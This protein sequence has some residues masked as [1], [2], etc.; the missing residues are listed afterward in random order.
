[1]LEE[2]WDGGKA[3]WKIWVSARRRPGLLARQA[4]LPDRPYRLQGQLAGAVAAGAGRRGAPASRSRRRHRAGAVRRRARRR[5][6]G[7]RCIGDIRDRDALCSARSPQP[8]RRSCSTWRRSR[9]CALSY[10]DPVETYATNV[11]GTVHV[12][13]AVRRGRVGAR[14]FVNVT[15]DK[16]YEN[17][18]WVWGYREDE[19]MGG[20]D[21]Y[22]N[23]KGCAELVTSRLPPLVLQQDGTGARLGARRQR[24]RRR[25]LGGRPPGARHP[26]RLRARRAGR[27][28][29]IR[30]RSARGSTCW[31]RCPAI[32][33]LAKRLWHDGAG[34]RRGVE[35]R[36]ARRAMPVR[37]SGS[38]SACA[39]R[40]GDGAG[41]RL[42]RRRRIRT[43]RDYLKL[44]ISKARA[45]ARL[46]AALDARRRRWTSIVAW[47]RA[48]RVGRGHARTS[49]SSRSNRIRQ[50][51]IS[52]T[53]RRDLHRPPTTLARARSRELVRQLC[54]SCSSRRS[55]SCPAKV[56]DAAVSGKVIGAPE[57]RADGRGL[58]RRLADHRPLQ[59]RVREA[60]GQVPRRAA[61]CSPS[62]RA[63]RP[64]WSRSRR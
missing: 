20:H 22:S 32:C 7:R 40:W 60:A 29:A 62:T 23:S 31:S 56:V 15:T 47:H 33:V 2:L 58:A 43:R 9:W 14:A 45:A 12:L 13:E 4:R 53:Q 49:A 57:M 44:D 6:H 28:S 41:W 64:T 52:T 59:R 16:C 39:D 19:P 8:S 10:A 55:P 30:R 27:A 51:R 37:C 21:P 42:R 63:R 1:M 17:R 11:M 5:R 35:L 38:S 18:E 3:P 36:P 46:A 50:Y 25:R 48:W 61:S 54:R 24:D 26:A 34:G